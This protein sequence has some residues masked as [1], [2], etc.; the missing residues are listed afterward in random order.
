MKKST[1]LVLL[2]LI[3]QCS[4]IS[5]NMGQLMITMGP[6]DLFI[7]CASDET[8]ITDWI[9]NYIAENNATTD[10]P[11]GSNITWTHSYT[12]ESEIVGD[13]CNGNLTVTFTAT[14]DCGDSAS[15]DGF[16]EINDTEPPS[17]VTLP[18]NGFFECDGIQDMDA[19]FT[20]WLNGNLSLDVTD[21]C[22]SGDD[23]SISHYCIPECPPFEDWHCYGILD[24]E[25]MISDGCNEHIEYAS[26]EIYPEDPVLS[27]PSVDEH[28]FIC[29]GN[30]N[31]DDLNDLAAL[32]YYF[33]VG[34]SLCSGEPY[35]LHV[36]PDPLNYD[37]TCGQ[38]AS[39][40][41][42]VEDDCGFSSGSYSFSILLLESSISFV[43]SGQTEVEGD[44][45]LDVCLEITGPH[46]D[47]DSY[48]DIT[49]DEATSTAENNLDFE[50]LDPTFTLTFPAGSEDQQCFEIII[51]D[52]NLVEATEI[53]KFDISDVY[54]GYN[55]IIGDIE[56]FS[57]EIQDNDDDDGD[58]IE[59]S[60]DNC[61]EIYNP[62][63]EDIDDD[64]IGNVCDPDNEV[65]IFQTVEG[66]I[67]INQTYSGLIVQ[68]PDGN[69]WMI[70]VANDG[71]LQTIFIEC[72]E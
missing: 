60:V 56:S 23:L 72:P 40:F 59:N 5:T 8:A 21:N 52:D 54:G 64:G 20:D 14:D 16:V 4:F 2:S 24:V 27:P 49:F 9:N 26:F 45:T 10:C 61:P 7:E 62:F 15:V 55:G 51:S 38:S 41:A 67:Y 43:N 68:S 36:S 34:S 12:S 3:F 28:V 1:S 22:A 48:V 11:D 31:L 35:T 50:S 44:I 53:A 32:D 18:E 46:P 6:E 69:C 39:F 13:N 29:D 58:G 33:D 25:F 65:D 17:F 71:T 37:F 70:T 66:N 63:Q 30:G 47:Q 57:L 42:Y 19:A